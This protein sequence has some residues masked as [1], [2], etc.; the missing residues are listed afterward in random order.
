MGPLKCHWVIS[1]SVV[2]FYCDP[3][4]PEDV[5]ANRINPHSS[6]D[7]MPIARHWIVDKRNPP[8]RF[9][10]ASLENEFEK[11]NNVKMTVKILVLA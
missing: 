11:S 10:W 7:A 5:L 8:Q 2:Y 6:T 9:L 3:L 1:V 4:R